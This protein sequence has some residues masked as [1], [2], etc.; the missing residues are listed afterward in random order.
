MGGYYEHGSGNLYLL[1]HVSPDEVRG[2][3]AHELTHALEDQNYDF[4]AVSKRSENADQSTAITAVIEASAT[5][6]MLAFLDRDMGKEKANEKLERTESK[7]AQRLKVA[8]SFTQRSLMLPYLLG[9]SFLLHGKPWSSSSATACCSRTWSRRTPTLPTPR[10]RSC[11]PSSTGAAGS[12][13]CPS[14]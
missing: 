9:F 1:D 6:V 5:A 4:E 3:I 13:T 2:V 7:R 12:A 10:G 14:A 11:I 8:P